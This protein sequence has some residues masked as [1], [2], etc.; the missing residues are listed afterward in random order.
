MT[1]TDPSA[2]ITI[3]AP[4]ED[5]W[6]VMMD[7]PRYGEWNP[8]VFRADSP[9]GAQVGSP[10]TLRVCWKNGAKTCSPE[11][12]S[13]VEPPKRGKAALAY[14]YEGLPAKLGLI[15][16]TR[17]QRLTALTA[18]STLYETVEHF[19]GPMVKWAGLAR[20]AD[21][22]RRHAEGLKARCEG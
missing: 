1:M 9:G 6:A 13:A 10:I 8:F 4:I 18:T 21:G 17:W 7:L 5:V 20:V 16:G 19:S 14:A 22:F 11:R 12:I 3:E 15:Q 2:S